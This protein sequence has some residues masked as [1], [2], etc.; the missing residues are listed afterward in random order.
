[1]SFASHTKNYSSHRSD[2]YSQSGIRLLKCKDCET[3][4]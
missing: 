1:M 3:Y 2:P 4:E